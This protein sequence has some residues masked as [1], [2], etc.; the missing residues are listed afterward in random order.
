MEYAAVLMVCGNTV[1]AEK[2]FPVAVVLAVNVAETLPTRPGTTATTA[3]AAT[4]RHRRG[5]PRARRPRPGRIPASVVGHGPSL[6]LPLEPA[7]RCHPSG[8]SHRDHTR[9]RES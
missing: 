9:R 1:P 6:S 7:A 2:V 3:A 8:G 5:P 4:S